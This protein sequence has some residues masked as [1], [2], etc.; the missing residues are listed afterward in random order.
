MK[1]KDI[2]RI[3]NGGI[4]VNYG[5]R[6]FTTDSNAVQSQLLFEIWQELKKLNKEVERLRGDVEVIK[7][8]R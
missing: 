3:E 5:D 8:Q 4:Q 2:V 7:L 6:G 1:I